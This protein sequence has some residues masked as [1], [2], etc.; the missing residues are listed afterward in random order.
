MEQLLVTRR[1]RPPTCPGRGLSCARDRQG[2]THAHTT[3]DFAHPDVVAT[4]LC[5]RQLCQPFPHAGHR[6]VLRQ[7]ALEIV[8]VGL[9]EKDPSSFLKAQ[10]DWTPTLGATPGDF[11]IADLLTIANVAL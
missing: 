9:A 5:R 10:P 6:R 11:T 3:D 1:E 4:L 2:A 8:L 7:H